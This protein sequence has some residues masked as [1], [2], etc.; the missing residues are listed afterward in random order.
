MPPSFL[1]L[2]ERIEYPFYLLGRS[3]QLD[4]RCIVG[5]TQGPN[6]R[7]HSLLAKQIG[8]GRQVPQGV[9]ALAEAGSE[10][11][12]PE[13]QGHI[14]REHAGHTCQFE[15]SPVF[16]ERLVKPT[17]AEKEVALSAPADGQ[18]LTG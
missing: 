5:S 13:M 15:A 9:L 14:V 17:Q 4:Q 7:L 18:M 1:S 2:A 11:A 8:T 10:K 12:Q 16:C 3:G 6:R